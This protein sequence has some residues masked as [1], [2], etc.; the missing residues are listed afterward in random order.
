MQLL[1]LIQAAP[2]GPILPR[3]VSHPPSSMPPAS[4]MAPS[5]SSIPASHPDREAILARA[6]EEKRAL[7]LEAEQADSDWEEALQVADQKLIDRSAVIE[8]IL[9]RF[10]K[11]PFMYRGESVRIVKRKSQDGKRVIHFFRAVSKTEA[12]DIF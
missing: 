6:R 12:E 8:K 10:G 9:L 3:S 4:G 11:G 5:S 2:L 1:S 7:F